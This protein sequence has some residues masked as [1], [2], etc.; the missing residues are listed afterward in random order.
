MNPFGAKHL[1]LY[2]P[3]RP[4]RIRIAVLS[5]CTICDL[6]HTIMPPLSRRQQT[7]NGAHIANVDDHSS[8]ASLD[9]M[10]EHVWVV[11]DNDYERPQKEMD[12]PSLPFGKTP[13]RKDSV[14][15]LRISTYSK[16]ELHERYMSSE[17]E[18][19]PS[20]DSE[21]GSQ[22]DDEGG[23]AA[24]DLKQDS[25]R[26]DEQEA[27]EPIEAIAD[28][29]MAEIAVAVPIMAMGRPKLID[30][31][32]LAPMHKRKRSTEK[33]PL[34]HI[35]VKNAA[36]RASTVSKESTRLAAAHPSK[37]TT[38]EEHLPKHKSSMPILAPESWLPEDDTAIAEE[39]EQYFL[40]L[41]L[42]NP[43]SYN[44]YDP[45]SL[46]P[47]RLSPRNSYNAPAKKPGSVTRARK[48]A[49]LPRRMD[50]SAGWKGLGR[51]LSL[52][53]RHEAHQP[54]RQVAKKP[55]MLARGG[56]ERSE[57][58]LIPPFPIDEDRVR[59]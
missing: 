7:L 43:P 54:P 8:V 53:K 36:L 27:E 31:A 29:Y 15:N 57:T 50:S 49:I 56:S 33:A 22:Y 2:E 3:E 12:F 20:P 28:E 11:N 39:D 16:S 25:N 5:H 1:C 10:N 45:Y 21:T 40:D 48:Q 19:S 24:V 55:K 17:E 35:A 34:S 9:S 59:D 42:R 30:I 26:N 32:A 18:P 23:D 4:E 46:N 52:V 37:L 58:P 41:Q 51:P 14:N 38:E 13:S 47:P 6:P 44:D